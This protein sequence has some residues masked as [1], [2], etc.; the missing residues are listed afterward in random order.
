ML[1][2]SFTLRVYRIAHTY[3]VPEAMQSVNI[4]TKLLAEIVQRIANFV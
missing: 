1:A 3:I 2:T 4:H